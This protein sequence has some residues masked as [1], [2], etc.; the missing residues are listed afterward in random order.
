MRLIPINSAEAIFEPFFD[1]AIRQISD[2][3]MHAHGATR[4]T[5]DRA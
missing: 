1:G 3:P 5:P 4:T 2:R